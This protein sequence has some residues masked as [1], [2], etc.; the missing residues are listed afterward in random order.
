MHTLVFT[1]LGTTLS[2]H[3]AY[4]SIISKTGCRGELSITLVIAQANG[5]PQIAS[6]AQSKRMQVCHTMSPGLKQTKSHTTRSLQ[7]FSISQ[8]ESEFDYGD[9]PSDAV[10][11]RG[12]SAHIGNESPDPPRAA[13]QEPLAAVPSQYDT[14]SDTALHYA[15]LGAEGTEGVLNPGLVGIPP[16]GAAYN[17]AAFNLRVS[18]EVGAIKCISLLH[19][20]PPHTVLSYPDAQILAYP[21]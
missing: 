5:S 18:P 2:L 7:R 9:V 10:D 21:S 8:D 12:Q 17:A 20:G 4:E 16:E 6:A 1:S 13:A 14:G 19:R 11:A 15:S 3:H